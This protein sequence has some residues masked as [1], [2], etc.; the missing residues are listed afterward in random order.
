[1]QQSIVN[2]TYRQAGPPFV[3]QLPLPSSLL[4][5]RNLQVEPALRESVDQPK[6]RS[7]TDKAHLFR[8][9]LQNLS[10]SPCRLDVDP[11]KRVAFELVFC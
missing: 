3:S 9:H 4:C 6:S 5:L 10:R 1:M 2:T 11:S 8:E 7:R